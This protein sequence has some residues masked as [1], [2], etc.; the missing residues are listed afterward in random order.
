MLKKRTVVPPHSVVHVPAQLER[1]MEQY[2][3]EP[4]NENLPILIPRCLYKNQEQP[5]VCLVNASDRYFTIK[6]NTVVAIADVQD[7]EQYVRAS[8]VTEASGDKES[9]VPE[10]LNLNN[11]LSSKLS[12]QE[13]QKLVFIV[14]VQ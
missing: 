7:A 12:V 1:K 8:C 4:C 13:K 14:G 2:V 10:L 5:V 6:R 3:I 11:S 9:H